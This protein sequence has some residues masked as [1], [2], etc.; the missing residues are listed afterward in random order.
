[1]TESKNFDK[2]FSFSFSA[3]EEALFFVGAR[4]EAALIGAVSSII[5]SFLRC[6]ISYEVFT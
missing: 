1:M 5:L 3:C 2:A 6:I 4:I